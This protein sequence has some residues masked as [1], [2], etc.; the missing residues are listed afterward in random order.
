MQM[1][2][3]SKWDQLTKSSSPSYYYFAIFQVTYWDSEE[4][5]NDFNEMREKVLE[6]LEKSREILESMSKVFK[7]N[8]KDQADVPKI[9][10]ADDQPQ[11]T[12]KTVDSEW[13]FEKG[14]IFTLQTKWIPS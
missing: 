13:T 9:D 7:Q 8:V 14:R 2:N 4:P 11:N 5:W 10:Q 6:S 1:M 12:K 3:R